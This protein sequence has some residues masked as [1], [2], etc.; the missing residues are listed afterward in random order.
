MKRQIA[1]LM[2]SLL[3]TL[4]VFASSPVESGDVVLKLARISNGAEQA[5]PESRKNAKAFITTLDRLVDFS[6]KVIS[7][8]EHDEV[9]VTETQYNLSGFFAG[10]S[11]AI[12]CSGEAIVNEKT[13]S[14][15]HES[16]ASEYEVKFTSEGCR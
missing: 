8:T 16:Y 6:S 7:E 14:W 13:T 5:S 2:S 12:A 11:D 9:S 15:Y 10:G 3:I 1:S 4:P